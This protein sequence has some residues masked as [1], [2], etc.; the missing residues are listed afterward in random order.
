[1]LD[2]CHVLYLHKSLYVIRQPMYNA[3]L[4][5]CVTLYASYASMLVIYNVLYRGTYVRLI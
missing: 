5:V 1:M 4:D 2:Y 3:V